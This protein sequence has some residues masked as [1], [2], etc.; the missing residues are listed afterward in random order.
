MDRFNTEY[1]DVLREGVEKLSSLREDT[2]DRGFRE[3]KEEGRLEGRLEGFVLSI[4]DMILYLM[5][6]RGWSAEEAIR[7]IPVPKDLIEPVRAEV[8]RRTGC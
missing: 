8:S 5:R 6:D 1:D 4:S 3:G 2:Y 7:N